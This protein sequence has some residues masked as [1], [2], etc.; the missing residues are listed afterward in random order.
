MNDSRKDI[1]DNEIRIITSGKN[2]SSA[3][4]SEPGSVRNRKRSLYI[5]LG[6]ALILII[7]AAIIIISGNRGSE[8]QEDDAVS[9]IES[10]SAES[11]ANSFSER[12]TSVSKASYTESIDTIVNGVNLTVLTPRNADAYLSVDPAV[13]NDKD[14]V[15]LAQAADIRGDNGGIAGAFVVD[16]ELVGKG[17]SKSGFCAIIDGE[18]TI[19]VAEATPLLEKAIE[20]G[21]YFFRQYPLV[22]GG[23]VVENKP[24]G[25]SV[26]RALAMI[27][28]SPVVVISHDK[29]T[30]HEFSE[31]L[32]NLGASEAI[33]LVGSEAYA[34]YKE[35]NGTIHT[36]SHP[37]KGNNIKVSYILWR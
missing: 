34:S 35:K 22:A 6:A 27:S 14:I 23:Q 28:G 9:S 5:I 12:N 33:Y 11:A 8:I 16:G 1:G 24:K 19:G 3:S 31:S 10:V 4:S 21:G 29:L 36:L 26:R 20:S 2:N 32:V 30:F 18:M 7:I 13:V 17:N 37:W 15:L 25:K